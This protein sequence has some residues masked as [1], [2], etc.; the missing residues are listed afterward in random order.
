MD[1]ADLQA[2]P[3][4]IENGQFL[5]FARSVLTRRL[6]SVSKRDGKEFVCKKFLVPCC[7]GII[8]TPN[9]TIRYAK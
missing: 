5:K 7:A 1:Y 9:D 4:A 2:G 3:V 6:L 8:I